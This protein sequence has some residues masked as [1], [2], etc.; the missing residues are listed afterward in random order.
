MKT[1]ETQNKSD[2]EAMNMD[3]KDKALI[4]EAQEVYGISPQWV[5]ASAVRKPENVAVIVTFGGKKVIYKRGEAVK[6]K[7]SFTEISGE[8]PEKEMFWSDRLNQGITKE[9]LKKR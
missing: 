6:T 9:E 5:L 4:K 3:E 1:K 8:L 7:L 2:T